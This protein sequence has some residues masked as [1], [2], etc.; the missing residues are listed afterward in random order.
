MIVTY[1][2][3]TFYECKASAL[4]LTLWTLM[5]LSIIAVFAGSMV[6][7]QIIVREKLEER[8]ALYDIIA[9]GMMKGIA[10]VGSGDKRD[11]TPEIDSLNDFW[12]D[13]EYLFKD[14]AF[15]HGTFRFPYVY[16]D[17]ITG[18][19]TMNF[20]VIDEERKININFAAKD[21][22]ER[23]FLT[24]VTNDPLQS[25]HLASA[26]IDWRDADDILHNDERNQSEKIEYTNAKYAYAPS[27]AEYR[28]LEELLLVKGIDAEIFSKIRDYVTVFSNG[29]VNI[30]TASKTVLSSL[31]LSVGLVDKIIFFRSG[32]DLREGT[33]DDNVFTSVATV[34]DALSSRYDLSTAER[35]EISEVLTTDTV[36]VQSYTFTAFCK[37]LL[38]TA[39]LTGHMICVFDKGGDLK[40]WGYRYGNDEEL[41]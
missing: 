15:R 10:I 1:S 2:K 33:F 39:R 34:A 41:N 27:N 22:L 30:N 38:D 21:T 40:Y 36:D 8:S 23:L 32:S 29:K 16:T 11:K 5:F 14:I 4:I 18:K 25:A 13:R 12:A 6:R 7:Q 26:I 19:R 20:G 37:S 17:N 31:G 9:S 28:L 24:V 3:K 35:D